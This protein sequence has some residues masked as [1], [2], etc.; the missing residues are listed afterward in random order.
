[1]K[2]QLLVEIFIQFVSIT[3]LCEIN[4]LYRWQTITK[5]LHIRV[6]SLVCQQLGDL[7]NFLSVIRTYFN[8]FYTFVLKN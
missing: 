3:D 8:I 2:H 1:M 4:A 5:T 7:M 6:A